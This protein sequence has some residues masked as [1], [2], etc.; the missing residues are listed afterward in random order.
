LRRPGLGLIAVLV[1]PVALLGLCL[2]VWLEGAALQR[3]LNQDHQDRLVAQVTE[4]LN[5][6]F[7]RLKSSLRTARAFFQTVP[8]PSWQ[9]WRDFGASLRRSSDLPGL[10]ALDRVSY[11][12]AE[13]LPGFLALV[14]GDSRYRHFTLWP[15]T[16]RSFHC[17]VLHLDR[18]FT[19]SGALGFDVCSLPAAETA[20][21]AAA[22]SGEPWLSELLPLPQFADRT[23]GMILAMPIYALGQPVATES[24][25]RFALRGWIEAVLEAEALLQDLAPPDSGL[26]LELFEG[27]RTGR[28][29]LASRLAQPAGGGAAGERWTAERPIELGHRTWTLRISGLPAR[30]APTP[31]AE[32][33]LAVLSLGLAGLSLWSGLRL[34]RRLK[35]A[36]TAAGRLRRTRSAERREV[37]IWADAI[38]TPVLAFNGLGLMTAVNRSAR[39]L[40]GADAGALLGQPLTAWFPPEYHPLIPTLLDAG[41]RDGGTSQPPGPFL[42]RW[43]IGGAGFRLVEWSVRRLPGAGELAGPLVLTGQDVTAREAA[44]ADRRKYQLVFDQS[45]VSA[46]I[47]DA[48]GIIRTVNQRFESMS[49]WSRAEVA[50][51][52]PRFL[53]SRTAGG[54]QLR[55]I[56]QALS[57]GEVWRGEVL[58]RRKDGSV[59]WELIAISPLRGPDGAITDFISVGEDITGLKRTESALRQAETAVSRNLHFVQTLINSIPAPLLVMG[60]AGRFIV[61]NHAAADHIGLPVEQI[62]GHRAAELLPVRLLAPAGK[63]GGLPVQNELE[64]VRGDG[65]RRIMLCHQAPLHTPGE[66]Q[67]A[68]IF[69]LIDITGSKAAEAGL[70]ESEE[71]LQMALA[72]SGTGIWSWDIAA[73]RLHWDEHFQRLFLLDQPDGERRFA[74]FLQLVHPDDRDRVAAAMTRIVARQEE[75]ANDFRAARPDQRVRHMVVRGR[76]FRDR[77]GQPL[78]LAGVCYDDSERRELQAQL[79]QTAKLATI[80][81]MAAGIAHELAQPLNI[82]RLSAEGARMTLDQGRGNHADL[83]EVFGLVE[84]QAE[85]MAEIVDHVR[86]F[87]RKEM[88]PARAFDAIAAVRTAS[89]LSIKQAAH[90]AIL[91]TLDLPAQPCRVVGHRVQLEQVVMNL[92]MNAR[93]SVL[94]RQNSREA[95]QGWEGWITV[96]ARSEDR[97]LRIVVTDNGVGISPANLASIFEAFFT[98]KEA[99]K[100]T[101][102][103]LSISRGIIE[104]MNGRIE[105]SNTGDGACFI[106]EL[107]QAP[108]SGKR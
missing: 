9:A 74:D 78:R 26:T 75:F 47:A 28:E 6:R 53:R 39:S 12:P 1:P 99:G 40:R 18:P 103:G 7:A 50:G 38:A 68:T 100:G 58:S 30:P 25:R 104:A 48:R 27:G 29:N 22:V 54:P 8:D 21:M 107:P 87:S 73:N 108:D 67:P 92:L 13:V 24:D 16:R 102:L 59:Y 43:P 41:F 93:D 64:L 72:A 44:T 96:V 97:T 62:L 52:S 61:A 33:L 70:R 55:Q 51:R 91:I 79:I 86:L 101:G 31:A 76:V 66:P 5:G 20:L 105:A 98:T 36:H 106:V 60:P 83:Y 2:W 84:A 95:G 42:T 15:Q 46:V 19:N 65:S 94:Q 57:R 3:A 77:Q 71:R 63:A 17:L 23:A 69:V 88:A 10:I 37:S 14:A 90:E 34:R 85:R 32:A 4:A 80:G 35:R 11:L 81:E 56:W 82:I 45:P 49:G 89:Q